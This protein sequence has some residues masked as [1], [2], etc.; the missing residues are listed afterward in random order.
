M[1]VL[2]FGALLMSPLVFLGFATVWRM[3]VLHRQDV[4]TRWKSYAGAHGFVFVPP[5]GEWPNDVR[6]AVTW[7]EGSAT[8]A[9][10]GSPT[11]AEP[12]TQIVARCQERLRG[13]LSVTR[14]SPSMPTRDPLLDARFRVKSEPETLLSAL[15]D[16]ETRRALVGFD[17]GPRGGLFY[18]EGA[19]TLSWS[20]H[21]ENDSRIDEARAIVQR[22]VI[23]VET[24]AAR[25]ERYR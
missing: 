7:A 14:G 8:Y 2:A 20:G 15:L 5:A 3:Q 18:D 4:D 9:L 13:R 10:L 25:S 22:V 19:I 16:A 17:V 21:E 11:Q 6:G 23:A 12:R 1:E 24:T